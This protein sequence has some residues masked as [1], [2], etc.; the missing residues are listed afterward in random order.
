MES[1]KVEDIKKVESVQR[2]FTS[3]LTEVQHLP[4]W[5]RLKHLNLILSQRRC[6]CYIII[7]LYKIL[8]NLAPNDISISF[9]QNERFGLMRNVATLY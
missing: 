9:H 6:E 8:K 3:R 5:E 2:A 1:L 7:H 4:Y